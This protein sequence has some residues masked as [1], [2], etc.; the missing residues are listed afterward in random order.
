MNYLS[1]G[2]AFLSDD[3]WVLAGTSLPDW[4]AAVD[5]RCRVSAAEAEAR[6][7]ED[8]VVGALA[9]GVLAHLED[10]RWF[11]ANL[12]FEEST[13]E[14][15]LRI[16][17]AFPEERRLRASFVAHILLEMLL[18]AALDR[19][20]RVTFDAYYDALSYVRADELQEAAARLTNRPSGSLAAG[21]RLFTNARFLYGYRDDEALFRRL[22]GILSRTRQPPLPAGFLALLPAAR[23]LVDERMTELL[24]PADARVG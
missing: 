1:H 10:D 22:Q 2:R 7:D 20:G 11:H 23:A 19:R 6:R 3:P 21:F 15:T 18:D 8:G 16:R 24:T 9:R 13:R 17:A 14:L 12:A 4:L 5:R